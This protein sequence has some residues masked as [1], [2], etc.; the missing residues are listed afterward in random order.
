[1]QTYIEIPSYWATEFTNEKLV[2]KVD[3]PA[4][5]WNPVYPGAPTHALDLRVLCA[6]AAF[7]K[8]VQY[9]RRPKGA[10]SPVSVSRSKTTGG[11]LDGLPEL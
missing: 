1:M 11:F 3:K 6:A 5:V 2:P 9:A 10:E 4:G 7:Y 8:G